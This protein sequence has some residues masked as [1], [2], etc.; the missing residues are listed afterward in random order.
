MILTISIG[1]VFVIVIAA[2]ATSLKGSVSGVTREGEMRLLF[3]Y[4]A[5]RGRV[6]LTVGSI[7][8]HA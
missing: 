3:V 5:A 1:F 6:S 8:V 7:N 2:A 4:I